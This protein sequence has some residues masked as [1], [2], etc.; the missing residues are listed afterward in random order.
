M[1]DAA[2]I[3]CEE[4]ESKEVFNRLPRE[5]LDAR[6]QGLKRAVDLPT[7]PSENLK[8]QTTAFSMSVKSFNA[9]LRAEGFYDAIVQ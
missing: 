5:I 6:G 2:G 7:K 4:L 3:R 9:S 8:V 1:V